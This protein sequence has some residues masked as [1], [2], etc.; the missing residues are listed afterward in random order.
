MQD[1]GKTSLIG[2]FILVSICIVVFV[3]V[4][5]RPQVG[6]YG[7]TLYVRFTNIDKIEVGTRV[8]LAGHPIGEVFAINEIEGAREGRVEKD[9]RV[10]IYELTLKIDSSADVFVTDKIT[11]RTSGLLGERSV[12][13]DP[14]PLKPGQKFVL[15]TPEDV[16]YAESAGSV[17]EAFAT[18]ST[19]ADKAGNLFD[20]LIDQIDQINQQKLWENIGSTARNVHEITS[21]FN[22]PDKISDIVTNIHA[23]SENVKKFS[24]NLSDAWPEINTT[25]TNISTFADKASTVATSV[26]DVVDKISRGEGTMGRMLVKEDLYL[27]LSSVLTKA[28]TLANDVNHYGLLFHL[29]KGW[30]RMRARRVNLMQQLCSAQEFR[31]FFNDELDQITTSLGRVAMIMDEAECC[32]CPEDYAEDPGFICTFAELLRRVQTLQENIN[33]YNEQISDMRCR[34]MCRPPCE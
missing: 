23:T 17:E 13:I 14:Q 21:A 19:L 33:L 10:Y 7:S 18:I 28:E 29:D 8:T 20:A 31:N 3:L 30:Q 25:I 6:D 5:L 9:K 11:V 22:K 15:V 1:S 4:Y 32:L 24:K 34:M 16:L 27:Q 26:K 2:I 12:E